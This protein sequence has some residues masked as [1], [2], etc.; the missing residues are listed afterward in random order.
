M[1][2]MAWVRPVIST[3]GICGVT[4]GFFMKLI[5]PEAYVGIVTATIVW[6]FKSRDDD[7]AKRGGN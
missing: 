4:A 1:T 7:N 2:K 5:S 3:I 6:W